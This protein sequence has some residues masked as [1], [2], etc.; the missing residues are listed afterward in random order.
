MKILII[1]CFIFSVCLSKDKMDQ[2]MPSMESAIGISQNVSVP[3]LLDWKPSAAPRPL[4]EAELKIETRIQTSYESLGIKKKKYKHG[5]SIAIIGAG[6][7]G[8]SIARSLIANG[9]PG[10]RITVI[11]ERNLPGGKTRGVFIDDASGNKRHY[12]LG[13]AVIIPGRYKLIEDLIQHHGLTTRPLDPPTFFNI[14]EGMTLPEPND[15]ERLQ[16]KSQAGYYL[17]L[18]KSNPSWLAIMSPDGYRNVPEELELPWNK[19]LEKHGANFDRLNQ[20]LSVAIGGSGFLMSQN[21]PFSAQIIR[22]VNPAFLAPILT[23]G[24][25]S[26]MFNELNGQCLTDSN[27]V[28]DKSINGFQC[29]WIRESYEL[30]TKYQVNFKFGI[31]VSS[32]K[33]G[34]TVTL[35][36]LK[37]S[38]TTDHPG[39][40]IGYSQVKFSKL[41]ESKFDHVF[42]T[43]DLRYLTSSPWRATNDKNRN[44]GI[45]ANATP[46]EKKL[47]NSIAVY[48]YKSYLVRL[49]NFPVEQKEGFFALMPQIQTGDKDRAV[50]MMRTY[51]ETD[52][53]QVW[54]YGSRGAESSEE[55]ISV[56]QED[57]KKMGI[58]FDKNRDVLVKSDWD[59]FPHATPRSG[60][61]LKEFFNNVMA[62]QGIGGLW[63]S[64]EVMGFGLTIEAYEQGKAFSEWFVKGVL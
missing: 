7:A 25:G 1:F 57:M 26:R 52:I 22:F 3:N 32:I 42:Y 21:P 16:L 62:R 31:R 28:S 29:L 61:T 56:F 50:L 58:D 41:G 43:G 6:I 64:S 15:E 19:F 55:F 40:Q 14:K 38:K 33:R 49:K 59:Y 23:P 24:K 48:P 39:E 35:N 63:L 34:K 11:D 44:T 18:F 5:D 10:S 53:F 17:G 9:V 27:F 47:Y 20:R 8:L 2:R 60:K 37:Q 46:A 30:A 54:G 4:T 51:K 45:L 13:A 12:E 36:L